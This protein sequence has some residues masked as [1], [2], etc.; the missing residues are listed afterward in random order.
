MHSEVDDRNSKPEDGASDEEVEWVGGGEGI[1]S[2]EGGT[3]D[4]DQEGFGDR[5]WRRSSGL[6]LLSSLR[7]GGCGGG[8]TRP[9][10]LDQSIFERSFKRGL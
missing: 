2:E 6:T 5:R 9:L 1:D 3:A 10:I 8:A 7:G 4:E